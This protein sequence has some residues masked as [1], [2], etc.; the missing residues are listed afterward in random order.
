MTPKEK[1]AIAA[2]RSKNQSVFAKLIASN[3]NAASWLAYADWEEEQGSIIGEQIR[4]AF[5]RGE[6]VYIC[7]AEIGNQLFFLAG[8]G[9]YIGKVKELLPGEIIFDPFI[10][11]GSVGDDFADA[12]ASGTIQRQYRFPGAVGQN[13]DLIQWHIKWE[14]KL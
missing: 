4:L 8:L 7:H 9:Y 5:H 12:L 10:W 11:C 3:P 2:A 14:H 6:K 1:A 13:P